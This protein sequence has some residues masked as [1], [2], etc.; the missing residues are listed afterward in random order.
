MH[1]PGDNQQLSEQFRLAALEWVKLDAAARLL[2]ET[3]STQLAQRV[4]ALGDMPVTSAERD[5]KATAEW[6]ADI[7]NMVEARTK[8]NKA[9]VQLKWIEMRFSEQQ[10]FEASK[11]AEMRL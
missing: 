6:E 5:V 2:E 4:K 8:A 9:K 7:R 3:K 1:L 11:R 10:S